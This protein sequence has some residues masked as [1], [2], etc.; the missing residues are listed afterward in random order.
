MCW[1]E[2]VRRPCKAL[3]ASAP[4]GGGQLAGAAACCRRGRGRGCSGVGR[5]CLPLLPSAPAPAPNPAQPR[6]A[7]LGAGCGFASW[8]LCAGDSGWSDSRGRCQA[9]AWQKSENFR[10]VT[11]ACLK[12]CVFIY[13]RYGQLACVLEKLS[14]PSDSLPCDLSHLFSEKG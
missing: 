3:P 4:R 11:N 14:R 12:K 10:T 2:G 13:Q 9:G 8:H 6:T 5:S 1:L 7:A